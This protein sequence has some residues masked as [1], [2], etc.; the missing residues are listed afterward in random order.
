MDMI[1][2]YDGPKTD[3]CFHVFMINPYSASQHVNINMLVL[4]DVEVGVGR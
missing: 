2:F 3:P 1:N 4:K